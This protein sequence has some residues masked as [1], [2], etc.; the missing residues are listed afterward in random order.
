MHDRHT[1]IQLHDVFSM[2]DVVASSGRGDRRLFLL[3]P[4]W[5][6]Y[7]QSRGLQVGSVLAIHTIQQIYEFF[8]GIEHQGNE[9]Q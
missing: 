2:V 4:G 6:D 8:V 7:R 5:R 1:V 3:M 9:H